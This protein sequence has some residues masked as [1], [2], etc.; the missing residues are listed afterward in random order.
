EIAELNST[1]SLNFLAKEYRDPDS[2]LASI[3]GA[4]TLHSEHKNAVK[5]V[6]KGFDRGRR[7]TPGAKVRVLDALVLDG[8]DEGLKFVLSKASKG[9]AADRALAIPSLRLRPKSEKALKVLL[10]VAENRS[11]ELRRI[12]LRTLKVFRSKEVIGAM[13]ERLEKEKDEGL[14]IEALRR[15]VDLTGKNIGLEAADWKK[16]WDVAEKNFKPGKKSK[17]R[18]VSI[19]PDLKYFG[20]EVASK[21]VC[22]VIDASKSMDQGI[23]GRGGFGRGGRRGGGR[24]G[25]GGGGSKLEVM[26]K[27]LTTILKKLPETTYVN[28]IYFHARPYAWKKELHSL[29][30]R[31]RSE[32]IDFVNELRTDLLTNIYD[33]LELALKDKR[34]DTIFLLSDGQPVGGKYSA[35]AD[36]L[37]E[38]GALNRLRGARIHTISFGPDTEFLEDLAEQNG[39]DYRAGEGEQGRGR[40]R[41]EG[42]DDDD[43]GD[44]DRRRRPGRRG[45]GDDDDDDDDRRRRPRRRGAGDDDDDEDRERRRRSR[46]RRD[47]PSRSLIR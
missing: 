37:R 6:T 35:P 14:R 28:I 15:L 36:I 30:G 39:G 10:D 46:G 25:G 47:D 20:I 18:T 31:G 5:V 8:G 26:K 13:I 22:F 42:A 34:V 1:S 24:G 11:P 38:I 7:W 41:G 40:G 33:S 12:A 16:W 44:D 32:A 4:S 27:E 21:R 45:T 19:T 3:V 17:S 23:N 2:E 29:K 9:R 43:E